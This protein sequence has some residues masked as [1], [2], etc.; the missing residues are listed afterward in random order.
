[1]SSL[2]TNSSIYYQTMV[3]LK[4]ILHNRVKIKCRLNTFIEIY[5]LS[6]DTQLDSHDCVC[7]LPNGNMILNLNESTY[8]RIPIN[9]K[10]K[11]P[12]SLGYLKYGTFYLKFNNF[13]RIKLIQIIILCRS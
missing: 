9:Y 2:V 7:L 4:E 1:M 11:S 8:E 10:S 5:L 6:Y 12:K 13:I 3:I